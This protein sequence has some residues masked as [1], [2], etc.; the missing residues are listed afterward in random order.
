MDLNGGPYMT[1][2]VVIDELFQKYGEDFNWYMLPFTNTSFVDEL[3]AEIGENHFLYN[4]KIYAVAKCESND[5]V[6]Y[7][8]E[9]EDGVEGYY[10]FH[11]TYSKENASGYPKYKKFTEISEVKEYMEQCYLGEG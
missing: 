2:K 4:Q 8:A 6:L 3:K 1:T 11:L 9:N 7:M 5:E 10:I